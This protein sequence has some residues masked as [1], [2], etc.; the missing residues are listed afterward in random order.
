M[1]YIIRI[2]VCVALASAFAACSRLTGKPGKEQ[3]GTTGTESG[4][5][6]EHKR[7]GRSPVTIKIEKQLVYN[8][9]TLA[10][11]YPYKDTVRMFQ[12]DTIRDSLAAI[13]EIQCDSTRWATLQNYR[14]INGMPPLA[15]NAEEDEYNLPE[16]SYGVQMTQSIPYY[17]HDDLTVPARY[18]RDGALVRHTADSAGY[19]V[20][21]IPGCVGRWYTPAK[22]VKKLDT[23]SFKK[24]VFVDRTNQNIATLEKVGDVWYVRSMNPATTGLRKPPHQYATP[25]GIFVVQNKLPKMYYYIDGTTTI[26]G[27]APYASRFTRGAY[28]HGVPLNNPE[29]P[30]SQYIEFSSTLG[31]TPRSHMCVRTATSHAKFIYDWAPAFESLVVVFD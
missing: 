19:S 11:T 1:K 24:V 17:T 7:F 4:Q 8:E 15:R 9:H 12:W 5:T 16:D 22:Y 18:C 23:E 2:A 29:T 27:F 20:I 10:D 3:E 31:T 6:A 14:N 30:E 13:E 21:I 26:A 25:T 28:V